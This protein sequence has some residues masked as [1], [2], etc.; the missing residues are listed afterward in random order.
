MKL[1]AYILATVVSMLLGACGGGGGGDS[2]TS[3]S[4]TSQYTGVGATVLNLDWS[5]H[6]DGSH[7][8]VVNNIISQTASGATLVPVTYSGT[9]NTSQWIQTVTNTLAGMTSGQIINMSAGFV[10]YTTKST[11]TAPKN[12]PNIV[13]TRSAGN[14]GLPTLSTDQNQALYNSAY[15]GGLILVG[16]SGSDGNI[17]SYS[18]TA[19]AAADRFV[20]V[21]GNCG[22]GSSGTSCSAPRVAGYSAIIKQK[23][24]NATGDQIATA[25]LN[26][27]VL[28]SGWDPV[29]Y[30]KG[31]VDLTAALNY[32]GATK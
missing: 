15:K 21:D 18:A 27:A 8:T 9:P 3:S 28:K 12:V 4:S 22:T 29:I 31:Q 11:I 2:S 5:T 17:A 6:N 14:D 26:T 23:Y 24:P 1:F 20:I 19:G 10:D 7:Q 16:A 30:G 25:I 32:L 13:I